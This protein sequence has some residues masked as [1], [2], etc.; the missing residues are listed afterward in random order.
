MKNKKKRTPDEE[1]PKDSGAAGD[2]ALEPDETENPAPV[3]DGETVDPLAE[4]LAAE[5]DKY[6]RLAAEYDNFRKR[7]QR[8]RENIYADIRADTVLKFLPVYDN[9]T[10]ALSQETGDEAYYK[11]IELIMTGFNDILEKLGVTE[12]ETVGERFDPEV[13]NAVMHEEDETKGESEIVEELQ[14]G[15]RLGDKVIRFSL[16]KVA[17]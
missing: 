11:G 12:I 2:E 14:K 9:L 4:E 6:L 7:S 8:E 16:V 5:K 17:N 15:F 10:R 13:H 1:L 3:E